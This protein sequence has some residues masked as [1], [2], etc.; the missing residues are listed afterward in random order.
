ME[1]LVH[2]TVLP[3]PPGAVLA[4]AVAPAPR[5]AQVVAF[6]GIDFGRSNV[7]TIAGATTPA[8]IVAAVCDVFPLPLGLRILSSR[9]SSSTA[10]LATF[11]IAI[12][13]VD[14]VLCLILI[15]LLVVRA[16]SRAMG[17]TPPV[18]RHVGMMAIVLWHLWRIAGTPLGWLVFH[19]AMMEPTPTPPLGLAIIAALLGRVVV[20]SIV[21]AILFALA[22]WWDGA[23]VLARGLIQGPFVKQMTYSNRM[24]SEHTLDVQFRL[25]LLHEPRVADGEPVRHCAGAQSTPQIGRNASHVHPCCTV[26]YLFLSAPI[27]M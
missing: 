16:R 18:S 3:V 25:M 21:H 22:W 11:I 1:A 6:R 2:E 10:D 9:P 7:D 26:G 20:E 23:S 15:N 17:L 4:E 13:G 5:R 19:A 27:S 24:V 12:A 14:I 8:C